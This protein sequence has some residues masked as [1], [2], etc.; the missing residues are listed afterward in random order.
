MPSEKEQFGELIGTVTRIS[1]LSN[2]LGITI[3]PTSGDP[4]YYMEFDMMFDGKKK[5]FMTKGFGYGAWIGMFE[6]G[7][8]IL[9]TLQLAEKMRTPMKAALQDG[10]EIR[11][12]L[13]SP[14]MSDWRE[15]LADYKES[16]AAAKRSF[17]KQGQDG[18]K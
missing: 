5:T 18:M 16:V 13:L 8:G 10:A 14:P 2:G 1:D 3:E 12:R 7:N 11:L 17:E 15:R 6:A 9:F 4:A